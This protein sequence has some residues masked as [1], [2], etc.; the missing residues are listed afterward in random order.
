[1]LIQGL[2]Y[3]LPALHKTRSG[4]TPYGVTHLQGTDDPGKLSDEEASL[5]ISAGEQLAQVA[6]RLNTKN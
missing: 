5:A 6:Q 2:P 3:Q 1:M 4:G